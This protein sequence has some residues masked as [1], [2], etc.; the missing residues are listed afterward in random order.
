MA[1]VL[2]I[3]DKRDGI[4]RDGSVQHYTDVLFVKVRKDGIQ[5]V[6]YLSGPFSNIE[7]VANYWQTLVMAKR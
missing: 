6:L 7:P 2:K 4:N 1:Y 5:N 3:N